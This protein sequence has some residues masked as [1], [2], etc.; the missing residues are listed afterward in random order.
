MQKDV[1]LVYSAD[2]AGKEVRDAINGIRLDHAGNTSVLLV[3][4][5]APVP[6]TCQK[7][8]SHFQQINTPRP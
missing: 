7:D 5:L 8:E 2:T 6:T 1:A 4:L 3:L